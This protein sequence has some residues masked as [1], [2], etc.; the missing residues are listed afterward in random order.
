MTKKQ[1]HTRNLNKSISVRLPP[2][3]MANLRNVCD[4]LGLPSSEVVRRCVVEGL[5]QFADAK[6]PAQLIRLIPRWADK[7]HD[8]DC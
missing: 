8:H 4:R 5:K 1:Y 7:Q 3:P 6:L 2:V